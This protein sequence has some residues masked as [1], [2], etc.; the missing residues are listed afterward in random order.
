MTQMRK[1]NPVQTP[2]AEWKLPE[3]NSGGL[4]VPLE[5]LREIS[6]GDESKLSEHGQEASPIQ[7][8]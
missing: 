8:S 5:K 3:F 6:A 4:L 1:E 7:D 2:Q